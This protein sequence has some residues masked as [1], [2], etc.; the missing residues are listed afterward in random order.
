MAT[1]IG[2]DVGGTF[3][4]LVFYDDQAGAIIVDKQPTTPAAPEEGVLRLLDSVRVEQALLFLH[5]T[6]VGLNSL[7]ERRG[8]TVGLLTTAGFRDVLEIR[9]GVRA[10]R[11]A[12]TAAP[13]GRADPC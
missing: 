2:I 5:G 8:A 12:A 11:A 9:R 1:R 7:L 10:A 6:T 13:R 3:T 4:D